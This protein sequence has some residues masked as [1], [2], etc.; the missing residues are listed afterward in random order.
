MRSNKTDS[1][2]GRQFRRYGCLFYGSGGL[3]Y[4]PKAHRCVTPK[5]SRIK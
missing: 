1:R 3:P 2:T 4:H 5:A